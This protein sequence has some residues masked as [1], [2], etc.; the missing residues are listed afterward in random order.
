[1]RM[2]VLSILSAWYLAG[3]SARS[4]F[5]LLINS[6]LDEGIERVCNLRF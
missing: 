2:L 6:L 3:T 5:Y 4:F 1:M